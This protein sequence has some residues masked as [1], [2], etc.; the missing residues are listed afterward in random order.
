[1]APLVDIEI[2]VT[3]VLALFSAPVVDALVADVHV[4]SGN[5]GDIRSLTVKRQELCECYVIHVLPYER[6]DTVLG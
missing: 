4:E 2:H 5:G 1:M 6:P 3:F